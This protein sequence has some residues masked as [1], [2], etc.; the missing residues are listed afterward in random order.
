MINLFIALLLISVVTAFLYISTESL[1][2]TEEKDPVFSSNGNNRPV[3]DK[4]GSKQAQCSKCM[5]V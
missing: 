5:N 2:K 3:A 4:E 1:K